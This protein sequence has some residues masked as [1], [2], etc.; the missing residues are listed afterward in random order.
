M[1]VVKPKDRD[2]I[3]TVDNHLFCV[4]GYLHPP[5]GYTAYLKYVPSK[6]GK[7]GSDIARYS[8][9]LPF[10]H[11]SQV[12]NTYSYLKCNHPKYLFDCPIRNITL[13][14]VPKKNVKHYYDP[15]QKIREIYLRGAHDEL[16]QKLEQQ[17]KE[18]S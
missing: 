9:T 13:S 1:D 10:Y 11:V 12:E 17:Q 7:W 4:V 5:D 15:K 18:V 16:E 3:Q 6:N 8:R 2:F 14:W